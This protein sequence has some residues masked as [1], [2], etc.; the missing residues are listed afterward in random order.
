VLGHAEGLE[1]EEGLELGLGLQQGEVEL[2]D[3]DEDDRNLGLIRAAIEQVS[4][5]SLGRSLIARM[6]NIIF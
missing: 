2:D 5:V 6:A 1:L 3:D 4:K